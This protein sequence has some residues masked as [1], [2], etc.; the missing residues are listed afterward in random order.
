MHLYL[1]YHMDTERNTIAI[2]NSGSLQLLKSTEVPQNKIPEALK[3]LLEAVG[4]KTEAWD[5]RLNA[6]VPVSVKSEE[7]KA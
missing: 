5:Q 3:E 4:T 1:S 6:W 2:L 7:K